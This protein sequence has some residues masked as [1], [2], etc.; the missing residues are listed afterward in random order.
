VDTIG[1]TPGLYNT[2]TPHSAEL[3]VVEE[4]SLD[5]ETGALTRSY[6][7]TDPLYWTGEQTGTN[8]KTP[9][10]VAFFDS[11]CADLTVDED[12]ELGPRD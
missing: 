7:A 2:S 3:H 6:T 5:A 9:S 1:F 12:V 8:T 4:F 11:A 10:N